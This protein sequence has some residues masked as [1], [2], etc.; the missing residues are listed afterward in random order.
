MFSTAELV[1]IGF[2]GLIVV[3]TCIKGYFENRACGGAKPSKTRKFR[4]FP[5][6]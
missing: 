5:W 3:V 4:L 6:S 1:V 2:V